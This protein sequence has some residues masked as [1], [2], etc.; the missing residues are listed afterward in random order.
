MRT[1]DASLTL[2]TAAA[3]A[4]GLLLVCGCSSGSSASQKRSPA[5]VVKASEI[6]G[7]LKAYAKSFDVAPAKEICGKLFRAAP[8]ALDPSSSGPTVTVTLM[9]LTCEFYGTDCDADFDV[10]AISSGRD[11][12]KGLTPYN[13]HFA[14]GGVDH[15][16]HIGESVG[17]DSTSTNG[18]KVSVSTAKTSITYLNDALARI[19]GD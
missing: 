13:G 11:D 12:P 17:S 7:A 14:D 4:A 2:A 5:P 10:S 15:G 8:T 3:I 9:S 1:L 19:S 18:C 6:T 16:I